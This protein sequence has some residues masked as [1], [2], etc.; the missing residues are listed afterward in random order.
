MSFG[1][2][3]AFTLCLFFF[4]RKDR[5]PATSTDIADWKHVRWA[6]MSQQPQG[7]YLP[8]PTTSSQTTFGQSRRQHSGQPP[9]ITTVFNRS[10]ASQSNAALPGSV[11]STPSSPMFSPPSAS[12]SNAPPSMASSTYN[13][14]QWS[15]S[16]FAESSRAAP[17][18][19]FQGNTRENTG[20]ECK[21]HYNISV[22]ISSCDIGYGVYKTPLEVAVPSFVTLS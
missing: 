1:E 21:C 11:A 8:A 6:I 14:R 10:H 16:G 19:P 9:L 3:R 20:M 17:G 13:P 22:L 2:L 5:C 4:I 15:R 12:L 18:G 7:S